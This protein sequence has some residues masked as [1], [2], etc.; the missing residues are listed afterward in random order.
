M[1]LLFCCISPALPSDLCVGDR[2]LPLTAILASNNST[3]QVRSIL[4]GGHAL[5]NTGTLQK[6]EKKS[7]PLTAHIPM[8]S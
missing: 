6:L 4:T 1:T 3:L 7:S 8:T 5:T 2:H